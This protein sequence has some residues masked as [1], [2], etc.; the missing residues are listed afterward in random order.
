M[1]PPL[2][3]EAR[4][5]LRKK[6]AG[7]AAKVTDPDT[8]AQ[9]LADFMGAFDERFPPPSDDDYRLAYRAALESDGPPPAP[10]PGTAEDYGWGGDS[11]VVSISGEPL[12]GDAAFKASPFVWRAEADI[13][14]RKWLYGRHLLRRFISVDVA[15]G[16]I[17]K[18]SVKI[19]EALAMASN[20]ALY[21]KDI[22]EGPLRVW[23]YNLEDPMEETERRLHAT[24]KRFEIDP[25]HLGERLFVDSGRDQPC[26]I[27][28][29]LANGARI[30]RPLVDRM[31]EEL[32]S[33]EIDVLII[34]PFVSSHSVDENN[35]RSMDMVVKEWAKIADRCNCAIN[36]VHHVR[37]GN[38]M[39]TTAESA[40]GA[41]AITDAA[42]SVIVYNRMTSEEAEKAGI[43]RDEASFFF[44]TSNDKANL[45]PAEK[46]DW[47]RMN[48]VD[49]D[50]GDKVGVAC[51][52]EW[53]DP[54]RNITPSMT[55]AAQRQVSEGRWRLD[56]QSD[57]WAGIAVA[58]AL[59]MDWLADKKRISAILSSWI[60]NGVLKVVEKRD[61]E[62]KMRKFVEVGEWMTGVAPPSKSKVAQ[63]GAGGADEGRAPPPSP[64]KGGEGEVAQPSGPKSGVAHNPGQDPWQEDD[65]DGFY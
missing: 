42:R 2:T 24:A 55:A 37:K 7:M 40:R 25:A 21:N 4:A 8:Q 13:P 47:F 44:R 27:A 18:S 3:P 64:L 41:K 53:P 51:P 63:G 49:L 56:P 10:P 65:D 46:A 17:G 28:E 9:M 45:A 5:A 20:R 19:G 54:F 59:A 1:T 58:Q 22:G 52:W 60:K 31:V 61:D 6:L 35:N 48:N 39:E 36:L 12:G 50:N 23:L 29:E 32:T 38:G 33:K 14:R 34:D 57:A 15:A 62:R 16:G 43:P 30:V 11:N 26:V